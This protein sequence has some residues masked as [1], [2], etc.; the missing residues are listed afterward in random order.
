MAFMPVTLLK[1]GQH[2]CLGRLSEGDAPTDGKR[3]DR[4]CMLVYCGSF[5]SMDGPVEI[6]EQHIDLL[7]ANHNGRL[8]RLMRALGVEVVP[9][10]DNPPL[11]LDHSTSAQVTVGRVPGKLYK[12]PYTNPDTGE[13]VSALFCE[14][15][16]VLGSENVEKVA[17]GRWAHVSIGADLELGKLNEL[18][19]T[20]FPAAGNASLLARM[21]KVVSVHRGENGYVEVQEHGG[22]FQVVT[23]KESGGTSRGED[24][25][26]VKKAQEEAR[27]IAARLSRI[28]EGEPM[29]EKLKKHLMDARK[30]SADEAEKMSKEMLAH[31]KAK[32]GMDDEKMSKH[33]SDAD[34]QEMSRMAEEHDKDKKELAA[35]EDEE[36][37]KLAAEDEE[38]KKEEE[39]ERDAKMTAGQRFV[40][41]AKGLRS[42]TVKLR[43]EIRLAMVG[44]RIARLR[45]VGKITPAEIKKIDLSKFAT[46][47]EDAVEAAMQSYEEREPLVQFGEMRGTTKAEALSRVHS[48]YRMARLELESRINMPSKRREAEVQMKRLAEDEKRELSEAQAEPSKGELGSHPKFEELCKMMNEGRHDELKGHLRR[49]CDHLEVSTANMSEGD[50]QRMS[51]LAK[52]HSALQNQFDELVA[53]A[54]PAIGVKLEEI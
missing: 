25:D 8:E 16:S 46:M 38:K 17:D 4:P 13:T 27:K 47:S 40:K 32:M 52:T 50:E 39:K 48:K 3:L 37:K 51:A 5:D 19:I 15:V 2:S 35:K 36:K 33:L 23:V 54:S 29:H 42:D 21:G 41:L 45:S 10:R 43:S 20:P 24:F 11:Q 26:D 1:A 28:S 34:D 30:M 14:K 6:T 9:I 18:S 49:M 53:L 44:S 7:I 12:A 31:A 22:K